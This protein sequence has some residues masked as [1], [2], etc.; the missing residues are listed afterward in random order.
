MFHAPLFLAGLAA[1]AVP[2]ILHLMN[3]EVPH[4]IVFPTIRYIL[5]GQRL[6]TGR[7]GLRDLWTLL[8]R[9]LVLAIIVFLFADPHWP[10]NDRTATESAQ[11]IVLV[12]DLSASMNAIDFPAF[13]ESR[14]KEIIEGSPN[15]DFAMLTSA[16]GILK[17]LPMGTPSTEIIAAAAA[18][19]PTVIPGSHYAA[20]DEINGLFPDSQGVQRHVYIFTDLQHQDWSPSALPRLT[21][22]AAVHIVNPH[23][24][25]PPN[26]AIL[27]VY[28]EIFVRAQLRRIRAT[29]QLRNYSLQAVQAKLTLRAGSKSATRDVKLR[30]EYSEKHVIDLEGPIANEAVVEIAGID[31]YQLDNAYHIW[32]GPRPPVKV[33]IVV[34]EK[35]TRSKMMET[36]FMRSALSINTPGM[37]A[38]EVEVVGPEL[39]WSRDPNIFKA[40]FLVDS[41]QDLGEV[42]MEVL[43]DY[44]KEGGIVIYVAGKR[45]ADNMAKLNHWNISRNRFLGIV[46]QSSQL[47]AYS[48]SKIARS[49]TVMLPFEE[50]TSDLLLFPIYRIAKLD[51]PENASVL[52]AVDD[53][54]P[55]LI[56]EEVGAGTMFTI[57]I[58][59]G[60]SWSEFATSYSF[61]PLLDQLVQHEPGDRKKRGV[62]TAEAGED[63]TQRLLLAGAADPIV[64]DEPGIYVVDGIPVELNYTRRESDPHAIEELEVLAQLLPEVSG[65]GS[66]AAAVSSS[67]NDTPMHRRFAIILAGLL[68]VELLFANFHSAPS[69]AA[70]ESRGEVTGAEG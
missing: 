69:T 26:I 32:I 57:A 64:E 36:L 29:V 63:Y 54:T 58:S 40:I 37:P 10:R 47:H 65:A 55:F 25:M 60:H 28:P 30:G 11:E 34:D 4:R 6:Q 51:A 15:A 41:V 49:M 66:A 14:T 44:L 31:G 45:T 67:G 18:L 22:D 13:A 19:R 43:Q 8:A 17:R 35:T 56:Q 5:K 39:F 20:L 12:Y 7:R 42:E 68:F 48:L 38:T 61:L 2:I 59:L 23:E 24:T 50:D 9:L 1:L 21:I 27:D 33:A 53:N 62:V 52:L 46:G 70:V 3:R 16:G